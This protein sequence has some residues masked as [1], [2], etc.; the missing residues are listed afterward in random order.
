MRDLLAWSAARRNIPDESIVITMDDGWVGVYQFAY[1]VLKEMGFPFTMY[2]YKKYVNSGG[3]SLTWAQIREMME[4]GAEV[5]SHSVSHENMT[6][7]RGK[8]DPLIMSGS[9]PS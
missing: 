7:R 8:D 3:R 4:A 5:G 6:S 9:C 1:P 2:L